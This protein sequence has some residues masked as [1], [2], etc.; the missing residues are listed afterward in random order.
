MTT[1]QQPQD[2]KPSATSTI[3]EVAANID[4]KES[5]KTFEKMKEKKGA[6]AAFHAL[7]F[8]GIHVI[9]NSALSLWLTY[10]LLPTK[11]AQKAMEWMTKISMP[12]NEAIGKVTTPLRKAF[13]GAAFKEVSREEMLANVM[14]SSRSR[15]ETAFMCIA[16]CIA[17]FPVKWLEDGRHTF[18]NAVDN[19]LHPGRTQAEKNAAALTKEDV[20]KETWGNLIRARIVGLTAVFATDALQQRFNNWLTY[21]KGNVDTAVWKWSARASEKMDT[22]LRSKI[23]NFFSRKNITLG[24]IQH[25]VRDDLLKTIDSPKEL[26]D[27]SAQ[28]KPLQEKIEKTADTAVHAAVHQEVD[29][30]SEN[31]VKQHPHLQ[32]EIE[33]AIFAEQ[34]RLMITKE[35]FLTILCA[36]FIYASAKA[37]FMARLMEK[38]GLKSKD[39]E[40]G[41]QA[42]AS[43][44]DATPQTTSEAKTKSWAAS[45]TARPAASFQ[46]VIAQPSATIATSL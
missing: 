20:P 44:S 40:G 12:I 23:V 11:P 17:L 36:S 2:N 29:R 41:S 7:N 27:F 26:K 39:E 5:E 6:L 25:K 10:N 37:P 34:G 22:G 30:L 28:L 9:M 13:Q 4:T 16:G 42:P 1:K 33:R 38:V 43:T 15:V 35:I 19:M 8:G 14:H 31:F 21:D 46:E 45:H 3:E 32:P 18:M 24:G